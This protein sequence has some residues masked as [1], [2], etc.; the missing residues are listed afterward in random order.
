MSQRF[1]PRPGVQRGA[2]TADPEGV[3]MRIRL[4]ALLAALASSGCLMPNGGTPVL[5]DSRAGDF[6]SGKGLLIEVSPDHKRCKVVIRDNALFVRE[7]W[8]DCV[9]VHPRGSSR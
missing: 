1:L 8:L 4:L 2:R 9:T 5:V 6:W 7:M 3:W